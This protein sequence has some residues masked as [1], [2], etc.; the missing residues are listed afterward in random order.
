[1]KTKRKAFSFIELIVVVTI[2]AI[3]S[4]AGM[5]SYGSISKKSRD[6]RRISDLEKIRIAL[7]MARQVGN[8][9]PT[10]V[11]V[12]VTSNY[13]EVS[14]KDPKTKNEYTY[15]RFNGYS[16]RIG[17]TLEDATSSEMGLQ[18]WVKSP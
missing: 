3:L 7:E 15:E 16:Y 10:S 4:V 17:A 18:Y 8:T 6:S 14:P 12:L 11:S 5:V 1:M 2:I 9:Y 13:L